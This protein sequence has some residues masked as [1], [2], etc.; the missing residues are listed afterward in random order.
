VLP[1]NASDKTVSW[2]VTA[3]NPAGCVTV[4]N[5]VVTAV[6]SGTA[7]VT[8]ATV[9]GFNAS[10]TFTVNEK[11]TVPAET[12]TE[13][14]SVNDIP[15]GWAGYAGTT[16]LAGSAVTKPAS[17]GGKGASSSY[18]FTVS[19]RAALKS[20]IS[21]GTAGTPRIIYVNGMID[22]TDEGS[23]TKLPA[24]YNGTSAALDAFITTQTSGTA[25]SA[26]SYSGWKT[27]YAANVVSTADQSGTIKTVQQKLQNA[28]KNIIQLSIPSNTTIIGLGEDSGI[29]GGSIQ[30]YN[31]SNVVVRNLQMIDAYD[32]FPKME[33]NDG[34]NAEWDGV[35][36]QGSKYVWIDH[37]TLGDTYDQLDYVTVSDDKGNKSTSK[38]QTYDG[39]C[40]IKSISSTVLGDFIT[41]SWCKFYNH[42]KTMLLG[43]SDSNTYEVNHQTITLH[44]NWYDDCAS[45]LPMVRFATIHIFNNYYSNIGSYAIGAR[46]QSRVYSEAN[47]FEQNDKSVGNDKDGT[48]YDVGSYNIKTSLVDSATAWE[49]VNYY[50][51]SADTA[52]DAKTRVSASAGAGKVT[53]SQ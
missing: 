16:D 10:C 52:A 7:T 15:S 13:T 14:I 11:S 1:S 34:L 3:A 17:Y 38:W 53:V 18:T 6:S 32:P 5:G 4:S 30:I 49:P 27:V 37:C 31:V 24:S 41:V 44:H 28:W 47:Y 33:A 42:D 23:G 40:D 22:M 2:T 21:Y 43:S 36:I 48:L 29:R 19:T 25:H 20:A 8:A 46:K 12:G 51:Y 9:N 26:T 50:A 45:R 35:V 39:L